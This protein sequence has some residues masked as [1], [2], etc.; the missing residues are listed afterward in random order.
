[1]ET[2]KIFANGGSQAVRLPKTCRFEEDEVYINKIGN[3][4]VLMPKND[5]WSVFLQG[6]ELF[7]E[8]YF[9]S[10]REQQDFEERL[11]L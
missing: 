3:M 9:Q 8:D 6:L 1:M 7:T 2:A 10:G 11:S 5:P 4:V